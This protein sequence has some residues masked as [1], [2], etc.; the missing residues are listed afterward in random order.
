M[1][2]GGYWIYLL[3]LGPLEKSTSRRVEGFL[4]SS[5]V[6]II[7]IQSKFTSWLPSTG[8]AFNIRLAVKYAMPARLCPH[9]IH[10]FLEFLRN[11][12]PLS[13]EYM[14]AFICQP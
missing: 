4:P 2:G 13:L 5:T 9:G 8:W 11:R 14:L 6:V 10:S 3:A 1:I 12:L 7:F